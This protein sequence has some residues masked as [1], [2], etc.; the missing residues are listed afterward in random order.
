M[1]VLGTHQHPDWRIGKA[2]WL[3]LA[4]IWFL[5]PAMIW[6][7]LGKQLPEWT[8]LPALL[9]GVATVIWNWQNYRRVQRHEQP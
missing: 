3:R 2:Q 1:N 9:G 4:D 8:R 6:F 7:G 5:G